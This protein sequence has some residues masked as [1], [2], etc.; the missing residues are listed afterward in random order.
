[1]MRTIHNGLLIPVMCT[2]VNEMA[3]IR[4]VTNTHIYLYTYMYTYICPRNMRVCNVIAQ[5]CD[6]TSN[7]DLKNHRG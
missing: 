1:M 5:S 2:I 7:L 6:T 3:Q 4:I